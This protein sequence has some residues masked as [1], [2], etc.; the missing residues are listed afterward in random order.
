MAKTPKEEKI[1]IIKEEIKKLSKLEAVALSE[2]G[3][4]LF[5]VLM[6]ESVSIIETLTLKFN[7]LTH[8][9]FISLCAELNTKLELARILNK[10]SK[11]KDLAQ[12]DLEAALLENE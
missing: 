12:K 7:S 4:L 1:D 5:N 11:D 6:K 3:K 9:E 10:S 8:L 2:G